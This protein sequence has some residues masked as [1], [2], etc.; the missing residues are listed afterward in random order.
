MNEAMPS[1]S[2]R[3]WEPFRGL[4]RGLAARAGHVHR[5]RPHIPLAAPRGTK[6]VVLIPDVTEQRAAHQH[7]PRYVT[8]IDSAR[9]RT[10]L[11]VPTQG[12]QFG[13][14]HRH[15]CAEVRPFDDKHIAL[16]VNFAKQAVIAIENS[17]LL[18]RLRERTNELS[19]FLQ[20]QTATAEV[21]QVINYSPRDLQPVFETMLDKALDLCES[22][23]WCFGLIDGDTFAHRRWPGARCPQRVFNPWLRGWRKAMRMTGPCAVNQ[24][25]TLKI[26]SKQVLPRRR[27]LKTALVDIGGAR[28]LLAVLCKKEGVLL[29]TL[30][31]YRQEVQPHRPTDSFASEL[32]SPNGDRDR[33]RPTDQ[34]AARSS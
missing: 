4:C 6:Q 13:R 33:E 24:S 22:G 16:V 19:E 21:L 1:A 23:L 28:S 15:L 29:G 32:C 9:A 8:M 31:T 26:R 12:R 17:R 7:D 27:S 2:P 14:R 25:Y 11:L 18:R 5:R 34:R 20:Q 30:T 10:M 3:A